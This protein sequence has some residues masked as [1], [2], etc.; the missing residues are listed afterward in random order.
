MK[1]FEF[2]YKWAAVTGL[3]PP[4]AF[5][6]VVVGHWVVGRRERACGSSKIA[7]A[8]YNREN[9]KDGQPFLSHKMKSSSPFQ[10]D[11]CLSPLNRIAKQLHHQRVAGL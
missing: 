7:P 4:G 10:T 8:T 1:V 5:G 11:Y 6:A 2:Q 9:W 3:Q